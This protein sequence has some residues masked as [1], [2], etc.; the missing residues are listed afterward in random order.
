MSR[1]TLLFALTGLMAGVACY[2]PVNAGAIPSPRT[3]TGYVD[4]GYDKTDSF[5]IDFKGGA[6]ARITVS[7]LSN[8]GD[9]DLLVYDLDNR[10]IASDRRTDDDAQ[11]TFSP[12]RTT[13]C[14]VVVKAFAGNTPLRYR[15]TTN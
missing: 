7:N 13:R 14:R 10:L 4:A 15:L 9:I 5:F 3:I 2:G 6:S 12:S 8:K 11:V 1:F